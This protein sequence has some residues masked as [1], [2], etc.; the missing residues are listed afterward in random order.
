MPSFVVMGRKIKE[1]WRITA[2]IITK[3][4]SMK[5]V[6]DKIITKVRLKNL[7]NKF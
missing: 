1:K 6:K 3:K 7:C 4:P 2:Y 5:R